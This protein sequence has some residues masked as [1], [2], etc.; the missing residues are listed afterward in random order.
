[1][2]KKKVKLNVVDPFGLRPNTTVERTPFED[3]LARYEE[4][5]F[6]HDRLKQIARD[7]KEKHVEPAFK[8]MASL[9]QHE[10]AERKRN[11]FPG[12]Y[13]DH[14]ETTEWIECPTCGWKSESKTTMHSWYG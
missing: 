10:N 12:S 9:C 2:T 7:Y 4:E 5:K 6:E 1:M 3:A 14:A 8:L 11:Y 13:Y